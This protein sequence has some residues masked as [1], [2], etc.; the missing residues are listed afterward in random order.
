M[1]FFTY[2]LKIILYIY[3][4]ISIIKSKIIVGSNKTKH[5]MPITCQS[6]DKTSNILWWN[7]ILCKILKNVLSIKQCLQ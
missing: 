1:K 2:S 7:L 3:K 6:N 5:I 4:N